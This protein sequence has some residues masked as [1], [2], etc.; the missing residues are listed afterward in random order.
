MALGPILLIVAA[1]AALV[2]AAYLI[3]RNWKT[4]W[5]GMKA[6]V[7]DVWNWIKSNWPYLLGILLGP[8]ALA[9]AIIYK[10]W[11]GHQAGAV[12][13]AALARRPPGRR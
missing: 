8:I 1:I 5:A 9:A 3:Y 4:I 13:G 10:H 2:V 12:D 11:T 6:A 7:L